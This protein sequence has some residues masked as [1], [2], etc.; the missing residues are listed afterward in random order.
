MRYLSTRQTD[1][2][3]TVSAAE[4]LLTGV[5]GDGGLWVPEAFPH[6]DRSLLKRMAGWPLA[7][8]YAHVIN[9]FIQDIPVSELERLCAGLV[10]DNRL[11]PAWS[12]S[13]ETDEEG[14]RTEAYYSAN[15]MKQLNPY[16]PRLFLLDMTMGP[17]ASAEDLLVGLIPRL[18]GLV[19]QYAGNEEN[20]GRSGGF[21]FLA[22]PTADQVT[23]AGIAFAAACEEGLLGD[24][25][26][27]VA[28]YAA[29]LASAGRTGVPADDG[30]TDGQEDHPAQDSDTGNDEAGLQDPEHDSEE[31]HEALI[32]TIIENLSG[33]EAP[34]VRLLPVTEEDKRRFEEASVP[35]SAYLSV[36]PPLPAGLE[37]RIASGQMQYLPVGGFADQ[38]QQILRRFMTAAAET[39]SK[40][41]FIPLDERHPVSMVLAAAHIISA[42]SDL[43]ADEQVSEEDSLT[44][45]VP[46]THMTLY[47]AAA[48]AAQMGLPL[49]KVVAAGAQNTAMTDFIRTGRLNIRKNGFHEYQ[50]DGL[51]LDLGDDFDA[52]ERR[53]VNAGGGR[54]GSSEATPRKSGGRPPG[55][56]RNKRRKRS[57]GQKQSGDA[58]SDRG[59]RR[60]EN[61]PEGRSRRAQ[62]NPRRSRS[63]SRRGPDSGQGK[64]AGPG[65]RTSVRSTAALT[66][67]YEAVLPTNLE[68]LMFELTGRQGDVIAGWWQDLDK[69]GEFR[70]D[71]DL[72]REVKRI[73]QS[74]Y[75]DAREITNAVQ[76]AYNEFDIPLD[77]HS[78]AG[79]AVYHR[80]E[81][82]TEGPVIY[83]QTHDAFMSARQMIEIL[84]GR[85]SVRQL[86]RAEG[87]AILAEEF[88]LVIPPIASSQSLLA[89]PAVPLENLP[90]L[91]LADKESEEEIGDG[92][93]QE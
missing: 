52:G 90:S 81:G 47:L 74:G 49:L 59:D 15:G 66:P 65:R 8:R 56:P 27:F 26:T 13:R 30:S 19:R 62:N 75:A 86:S 14:K 10:A 68:R 41:S 57:D 80:L 72:M 67:H 17:T 42:Y 61:R 38:V 5:P 83:L 1:S 6:I 89:E 25:D 92:L 91:L 44:F 64:P 24:S 37:Q 69:S 39:D 12:G 36:R 50:A 40:H 85:K 45:V 16:N 21:R 54:R 53:Q 43:L 3:V 7:R 93:G 28:A 11:V 79:Y 76:D 35:P 33:G 71:G 4:A 55:K 63:R 70:V 2:S 18:T 78:A 87:L 9:L 32:N 88:G 22:G 84:H 20:A 23:A 77:P 73:F 34:G 58:N 48:Y 60:Q 51:D 31:A 82:K 46:S 29:D